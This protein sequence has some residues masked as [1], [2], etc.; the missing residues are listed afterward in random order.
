MANTPIVGPVFGI[1]GGQVNDG[2]QAWRIAMNNALLKLDA[3]VSLSVINVNQ[4]LNPTTFQN[5]DRYIV[6]VGATGAFATWD[7]HIAVYTYS[8]NGTL[9]WKFY[10]PIDGLVAYEISTTYTWVYQLSTTSWVP[11]PVAS[12]AFIIPNVGWV[13]GSSYTTA[14]N[15]EVT[16]DSMSRGTFASVKYTIQIKYQTHYQVSELLL[17]STSSSNTTYITEYAKIISGLD[18]GSFDARINSGNIELRF[19]PLYNSAITLRIMKT[20]IFI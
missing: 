18:L 6:A 7:R 20:E 19:T 9:G 12:A 3:T 1:Y 2:D 8:A 16:V 15:S 13:S 5:G 4:P 11:K 10:P 14:N 17:T